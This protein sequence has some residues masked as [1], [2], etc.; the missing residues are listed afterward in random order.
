[1]YLSA[2][3]FWLLENATCGCACRYAHC[4]SHSTSCHRCKCEGRETGIQER[5]IL[6]HHVGTRV[7]ILGMWCACRPLCIHQDCILIRSLHAIPVLL[8]PVEIPMTWKWTLILFIAA[9]GTH[10]LTWTFPVGIWRPC[11]W[12]LPVSASCSLQKVAA[13]LSYTWKRHL[14]CTVGGNEW[15][16]PPCGWPSHSSGWSSADCEGYMMKG[17]FQHLRLA[18]SVVISTLSLPLKV[19]VGICVSTLEM[20][21]TQCPLLCWH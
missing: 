17:T 14:F 21:V 7:S 8:F 6:H 15:D 18:S 9:I 10:A 2:S 3:Y 12:Q 20:P 19:H 13:G 1:M 5:C 4:W 16:S 11:W